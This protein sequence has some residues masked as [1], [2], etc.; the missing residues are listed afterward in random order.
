MKSTAEVMERI[1]QIVNRTLGGSSHEFGS[2]KGSNTKKPFW[3]WLQVGLLVSGLALAGFYGA[4]RLDSYLGSRAALSNFKA[5][6]SSAM[7]P[8]L[9]PIEGRVSLDREP[10]A[11]NGEPLRASDAEPP[12]RRTASLGVLEIPNVRLRVPVLDGTDAFTLNHGAGRIA[13]TA[14]PGED[15]NIGIAGHRDS[16]FRKL[17][18]IKAGDSILLRTATGIDTYVVDRYQ[19]VSPSNVSVLRSEAIPSLTLVTCYPFY[20][21]GNAPKRFVVTAYLTNH[22][23]AGSTTSSPRPFTQPTNPTLEEQ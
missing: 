1:G 8:D 9:P 16:F 7:L 18:D 13:G 19:V 17:K 10:N 20:F 23:A 15:G 6:E 12:V 11:R 4:I 2:R 3:K 5:F 22:A 21:I 14:R